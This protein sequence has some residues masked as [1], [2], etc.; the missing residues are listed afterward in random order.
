MQLATVPAIVHARCMRM[1]HER[2]TL[3]AP[4]RPARYATIMR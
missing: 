3:V 1:L 2:L 4:A